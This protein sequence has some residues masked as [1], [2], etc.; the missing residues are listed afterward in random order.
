MSSIRISIPETA[1]AGEVIEIKTLIQHPMESG[2]GRGARGQVIPRDIIQT[3]TCDY[4]GT[5]V[6]EAKFFPSTAANPFLTFFTR[7]TKSGT[8]TFTWTDLVGET[9]VETRDLIVSK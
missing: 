4:N 1:E 5:T 6:F 7:A 3:F 8:L 2:F 9:W